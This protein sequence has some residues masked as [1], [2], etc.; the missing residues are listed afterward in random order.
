MPKQNPSSDS[1]ADSSDTSAENSPFNITRI[2]AFSDNYLWLLD[3]GESALVV[4]PGD[5]QPIIDMLEAKNL[6]LDYILTTHHH[7]DH[8]GGV[9]TLISR[10]H[11]EVIG[12]QSQYIPQVSKTVKDGEQFEIMGLS[13]KVIEVPGH[14]LDHIAY[15]IDKHSVIGKPSAFEQPIL[16]CGDTL[17]AGGCGRVFEGT[18]AQMRSSLAKLKRLPANTLIHCAHEYTQANLAFAIAVEPKN[19]QL[20]DRVAEVKQMRE[21]N[22]ATVP[23]KL[24]LE[25]A[26]NPFLRYDAAAV[27]AIAESRKNLDN[28][29]ADEVF[30]AIREWKD[31]F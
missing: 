9:D 22:Q 15:F 29:E 8:I 6:K 2:P 19:Q 27:I 1:H 3:D 12:P 11:P 4:D 14:T 16:F 20:V 28:L 10:Y 5:A 25:L 18:F 21:S 24:A 26:T 31:N 13:I 23:S 7:P 30:G 17:F